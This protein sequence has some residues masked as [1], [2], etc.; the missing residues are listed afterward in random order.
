MA[1][2]PSGVGYSGGRV[3]LPNGNLFLEFDPRINPELDELFLNI[4]QLVGLNVD[5]S[6][7]PDSFVLDGTTHDIN[8]IEDVRQEAIDLIDAWETELG[9]T[10]EKTKRLIRPLILLLKK[11]LQ[12]DW[13]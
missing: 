8:Y 7:L 2:I 4:G 11:M 3:F 5:I 1:T 12:E 6:G 9:F 13:F 10:A